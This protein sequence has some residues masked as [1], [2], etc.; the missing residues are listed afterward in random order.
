MSDPVRLRFAVAVPDRFLPL[1]A[2]RG[3]FW[4]AMAALVAP[5]P[6]ILVGFVTGAS[7]A[8]MRVGACSGWFLF[9]GML[10]WSSWHTAY[11]VTVS[12]DEVRWKGF[13]G[14]GRAPLSRLRRVRESPTG[15][16]R[17][18]FDLGPLRGFTIS[19]AVGLAE[20]V[21]RLQAMCPYLQVQLP[22]SVWHSA[23]RHPGL[24]EEGTG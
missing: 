21:E 14:R 2:R 4:F 11:E 8:G 15:R 10:A 9:A 1:I 23:H 17:V 22:P 13:P 7:D 20:F 24:F 16:N 19:P 18:R 5:A 12:R 6:W 3:L